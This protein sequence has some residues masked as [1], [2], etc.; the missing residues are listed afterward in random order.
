[1]S[2]E[3]AIPV[4]AVVISLATLIMTGLSLRGKASKEHLTETDERIKQMMSEI[5][6]LQ[7]RIEE[8]ERIRK[9]LFDNNVEL[10]KKLIKKK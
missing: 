1:M 10:M 6:I 7:K 8:C 4:A 9:E 5:S 3:L 2:F